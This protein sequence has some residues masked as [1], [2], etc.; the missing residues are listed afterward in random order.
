VNCGQLLVKERFGE[1]ENRK[2]DGSL[3][4]VDTIVPF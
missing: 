1:I 4:W 3:Y 2:K